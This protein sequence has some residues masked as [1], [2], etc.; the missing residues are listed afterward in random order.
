MSLTFRPLTA[1]MSIWLFTSNHVVPHV[2]PQTPERGKVLKGTL[3]VAHF[4]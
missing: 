3:A 1:A 2:V 4:G